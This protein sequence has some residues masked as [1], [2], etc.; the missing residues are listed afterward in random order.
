[1]LQLAGE[2]RGVWKIFDYSG[3]MFGIAEISHRWSFEESGC[4]RVTISIKSTRTYALTGKTKYEVC[5]SG[6]KP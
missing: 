2:S 6:I 4:F 3:Q 5:I 1:M